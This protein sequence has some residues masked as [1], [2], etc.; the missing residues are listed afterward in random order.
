MK[1]KLFRA[2]SLQVG[3]IIGAG[4]F[5][6]PYAISHAGL[7][8]GL[9]YL[10]FLTG[11]SLLVNLA[12]T[13][14]ILRTPGDHQLTGYSR[15]YLGRF[16]TVLGMLCLMAGSYG[17]ILAY[18]TQMG[19]FFGLL[20]STQNLDAVYSLIFFA[21]AAA[22]V[23]LGLKRISQLEV[24]VVPG[25]MVMIGLIIFIGMPHFSFDN[26]SFGFDSLAAALSPYGVIFFALSGTAVIPEIEEVL[27]NQHK[28][29]K[30]A[31][32]WGVVI[33]ALVY[34]IFALTV[35]GVSGKLTSQ[36]A[37]SGLEI[38]LPG[39]AVK[40]GALLGILAMFSSFLTL[41]YVLKEM[42]YRDFKFNSV[43]AWVASLLPPLIL[44]GMGARSFVKILEVTGGLMGGL[45]GILIMIM[46]VRAK[47]IGARQPPFS[48][49]IPL[50]VI[51]LICLVFAGGILYQLAPL[52]QLLS[53]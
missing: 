31:V 29:V 33:P 27:R 40:I 10:F 45:V 25:I 5:G 8:L 36:D 19:K 44:F 21:L 22:A 9:F 50:V 26:F 52:F 32:S 14:V 6:L 51:V 2:I 23:F 46:F 28:L 30:K 15:L 12:Y 47:K 7:S 49:K 38:F 1:T 18:T 24:L 35:I 34:L 11:I 17:A 39:G 3:T 13:E 37:I 16:G 43:V 42:F 48:L 20:V 53:P 4:V 41:G